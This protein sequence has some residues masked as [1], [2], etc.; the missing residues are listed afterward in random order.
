M[1]TVLW[2]AGLSAL[3]FVAYV[4]LTN[5]DLSG[6]L[7][8]SNDVDEA[9]NQIGSWGTKQRVTGTG[10]QLGGKLKEGLGQL[11]GD[12]QT[13]T[14]GVVDQVT[15]SVKDAAGQAAHAVEDTIHD[16]NR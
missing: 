14:S 16:L 6:R 1:K 8:A 12:E 10:S 15:G 7:Q 2:L 4:I 9:G 11:T 13:E 5:N 3:G